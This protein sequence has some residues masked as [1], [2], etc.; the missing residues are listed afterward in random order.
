MSNYTTILNYAREMRK[1]P[2]DA[3]KLM[4]GNLR[5]RK[6]CGKKFLR[7]YIIEHGGF[8]NKVSYFI[9]DFYCH[10][11]KLIVEIDGDIHQEQIEYDKLREEILTELG[12]KVIRFTNE[13]VFSDMDNALGK[14]ATILDPNA[15]NL[16][17]NQLDK[18]NKIIKINIIH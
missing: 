2:T 10:E 16:R 5:K 3:E 11:H 7:Q 17:K 8:M 4:W 1:N 18:N 12:Y 14:L 9:A 15:S 13:K 6:L